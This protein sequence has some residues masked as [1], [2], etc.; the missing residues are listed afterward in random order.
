MAIKFLSN[1]NI[2]GTLE[3]GTLTLGGSAIVAAVGMT[4]Q[5]DAG[6]V[7]AITIDNVGTVTTS[8]Y[9]KIPNYLFHDGN[10]DTFLQFGTDTITL[11]GDSGIT[12]DGPVTANETVTITGNITTDGIFINDSAPD[13]NVFEAIQSGRKMAL[14]TYFSSNAS[15]SEWRFRTSTGNVNGTTTDALILKPL[16]A[17]FAGNVGI[18]DS[19]HG[20]ASLT[21]KNTSQHIRFENNGEFAFVS[22]LSTGE[23]DIFGHGTDETINF[24]TGTGGGTVAMIIVGD[25]VGIGTP[26]AGETYPRQLLDIRESSGTD[27]PKILVKYDF[28]DTTTPTT[29]PTSSL[30][31]SPGQF[32]SDDTAPRVVGYRTAD[33]SSAAARSAGLKFGVAQNNAAKDAVM[34]TEA[35]DV[36][37]LNGANSTSA[38]A[39]WDVSYPDQGYCLNVPGGG[40]KYF[41]F[42]DS[43][44]PS[45]GAGM[46][47][48]EVSNFY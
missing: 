18:G 33:F 26:L 31:L 16:A 43:Q 5:V 47:Y 27:Y 44:T 11:R 9:L 2:D 23:L 37:Q 17:T 35:S 38:F 15:D 22:V 6:S 46:R 42:A 41:S 14:Y 36:W 32:S 7:N 12:L 8:G 25:K 45:Y 40:T 10:T 24:R 20:T 19:A 21:L 39:P 30:L 29:A 3:V 1:E 13:G 34:I 4:L 28:N 48:F